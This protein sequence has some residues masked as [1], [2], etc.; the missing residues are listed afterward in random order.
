MPARARAS[1]RPAEGS[2]RPEADEREPK[3]V[4]EAGRCAPGASGAAAM[5]R[6]STAL[7]A[8]REGRR[9]P[10]RRAPK[11]PRSAPRRARRLRS[12][13]RAAGPAVHRASAPRGRGAPPARPPARRWQATRSQ[14]RSLLIVGLRGRLC[15]SAR[16]PMQDRSAH[17]AALEHPS[18]DSLRGTSP[19]LGT[20]SAFVVASPSFAARSC[21]LRSMYFVD[22]RRG[23]RAEDAVRVRPDLLGRHA[24]VAPSG[25]PAD[26]TTLPEGAGL[27]YLSKAGRV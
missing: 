26:A 6:P 13:R 11:S 18:T 10:H 16:V 20:S 3:E 19:S 22:V 17:R 4:G 2:A 7:P 27:P 24:H 12:R 9:L 8:R 5:V 23:G 1:P 21:F 14:A 15:W 25:D